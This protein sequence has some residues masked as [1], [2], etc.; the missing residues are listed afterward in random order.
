MYDQKYQFFDQIF[1]NLQGEFCIGLNKEQC[2]THLNL[3]M[4][5]IF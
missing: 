5:E 3:R 4:V 1:P 2:L